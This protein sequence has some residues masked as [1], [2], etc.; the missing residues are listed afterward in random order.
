MSEAET[1]AGAEEA[2]R[3][4]FGAAKLAAERKQQ[5]GGGPSLSEKLSQITSNLDGLLEEARAEVTARREALDAAQRDLS[6]LEA[7]QAVQRG[8]FKL[9]SPEPVQ[10]APR[11]SGGP[12]QPR[13]AGREL[14]AKIMALI[15][16]ADADGLPSGQI[17]QQIGGDTKE[18]QRT[19][20]SLAQMKKNGVLAHN[21][22]FYS[23]P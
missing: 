16:G 9:T 23:K 1:V 20:N 7:L 17:V 4:L 11:A 18:Q 10:R 14:Q 15:E 19:R 5:G 2:P 13:E 8:T 12:R 3:K 22:G 21:N 6:T